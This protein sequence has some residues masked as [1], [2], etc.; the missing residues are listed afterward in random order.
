MKPGVLEPGRETLAELR[1]AA[2]EEL[3]GMVEMPR[4]L[5]ISGQQ[6][7]DIMRVLGVELPLHDGRGIAGGGREGHAGG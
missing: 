6:G 3:V 1:G 4:V 5:R 7:I 2:G